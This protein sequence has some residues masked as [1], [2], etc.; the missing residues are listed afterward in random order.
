MAADRLSD[1]PDDLLVHML[2]FV[3]IR[4]A[5]RS[6]SLSRRWRRPLPLWLHADTVNFDMRFSGLRI[7]LEWFK[8][9]AFFRDAF[10]ALDGGNASVKALSLRCTVN[11]DRYLRRQ[12][13]EPGGARHQRAP[14]RVGST[15]HRQPT[16]GR[17]CVPMR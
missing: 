15:Q 17:R 5:A 3:P 4:E 16:A 12:D 7:D 6:T 10:A 1:L 8:R 14:G 11:R 9:W 2:S 13:V